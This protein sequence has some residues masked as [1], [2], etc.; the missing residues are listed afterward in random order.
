[1]VAGRAA[2]PRSCLSRCAFRAHGCPP[3]CSGS[4]GFPSRLNVAADDGIVVAGAP[5]LARVRAGATRVPAGNRGWRSAGVAG[6]ARP[7]FLSLSR[8]R[9]A[10]CRLH[11]G[12][13]WCPTPTCPRS[14]LGAPPPTTTSSP[15]RRTWLEK[16]LTTSC[17]LAAAGTTPLDG[18]VGTRRGTD[19]PFHFGK[20]GPGGWRILT[21]PELHL[22][23]QV[24][25]PDIAGW[26]LERMPRLPDTAY[27]T[28]APTGSA[29]CCRR[30]RPGSTARRNCASTPSSASGHAWLVDPILRTLEVLRR[31]GTV[32]TLLVTHAGSAIE[33]VEP[34]DA[35][36][37]PL[38]L[39]WED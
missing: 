28:A 8:G 10:A 2:C 14:E 3:A 27:F 9:C 22:G 33:R 13:A 15:L 32:W 7:D 5:R 16:S 11:C 6:A 18:R 29:R 1:M 38:G 4:P 37:F 20:G 39:L 24:L 35:I 26:R 34:F 19:A 12:P 36:E 25:V 21:E 17:G 30:R 31:D 23:K